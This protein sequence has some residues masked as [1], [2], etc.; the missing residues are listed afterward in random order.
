MDLKNKL[1]KPVI[2]F[3]LILIAVEI[4][5]FIANYKP[6]TYLIG[7]DN[8]MPEF[9]LPLNLNRAFFSIWQEYRGLGTLDG[10][11]HAANLMHTIYIA[12]LSILLPDSTLRYVYTHL[13]HI[14]GGISFFFLLRKLTKNDNASFI[15]SLFYMFNLGVI[16]MYFAPLEVFTTHFAALPLLALLITNALEKTN[17][18]SLT[19]LFLGCLFVSPQG[20]VP[21]VF[22][23]FGILAG[24]MLLVDLIKHRDYRKIFLIILVI[25][26]ANAFWFIPYTVSA[27]ETGGDIKNSRINQ[28]SSEEIFF[29]NK[30]FGDIESVASLKGFMIDTIELD[31]ETFSNAYFMGVW[32]PLSESVYYLPLYLIFFI[33][34]GIGI[35]QVIIKGKE[36]FVPYILTII[37]AFIVLANNTPVAAE[38]NNVIRGTFPLINEALR[39]PFTKFITL[40][41]FCF[42]V[43]FTFGFSFIL[44]RF[45]KFRNFILAFTL[46]II[47]T[48][49]LPAFQGYFTSPY[50]KQELPQE[51]LTFFSD[52][53][54][55]DP[56]QR[57]V[58]FPVQT[59]WNWQYRNWGHRGS[60]FS[61]YGLPQP[62]MERA[63]DPWSPYDE[64]FYNEISYA[65][66]T[67]DSELFNNVLKKYD[68][69]YILVDETILNAIS[70]K[71]INYDSLEKFLHTQ[72]NLSREK[73][74]G[75]LKLY[76]V[77]KNTGWVYALDNKTTKEV[78]P[79]YT[80]EKADSI[81]AL[82]DN[83]ITGA[84]NPSVVNLFPA[85]FS[86]KLQENQEFNITNNKN[87]YI[88]TPKNKFPENLSNYI[89]RIPSIFETE[90]LVPV[91]VEYDSAQLILTPKYPDIKINGAQVLINDDPIKISPK[92]ITNPISVEFVDTK[93]KVEL[94]K[95]NSYAY[96]LNPAINSLKLTD[97]SGRSEIVTLDT[98]TLGS[99]ASYARL[100]DEKVN[101]V[102]ISVPKIAS[103]TQSIS[104]VI[105][106]RKYKINEKVSKFF[107]NPYSQTH[108]RE[109]FGYVDLSAVD[110]SSELTFY[111][112][113][114]FHEAS[115]ILFAKT[116]YLS[117]L[118]MRF[119]A[120]ND[121]ERKAEVETVFSKNIEDTTVVIP[122]ASNFF[123]G[124]GFHFIVKSV[125]KELA[126][127]NIRGIEI[128]PLP[129]G[130]IKGIKF[131]DQET[132]LNSGNQNPKIN[133]GSQ[134]INTSLYVATNTKPGGYIV[135]S[136]AFDNG[137][138]AYEVKNTG[139]LN[140]HFPLI[141]GNKLENHIL[142]N[143]W[144]NGWKSKNGGDT[145]LIF[146]PSYFQYLG[147]F[148]T[149]TT[150][151]IFLIVILK[152]HHEKTKHAHHKT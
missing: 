27:V 9:D 151:L 137:W 89:L 110:G 116:K 34:M 11:A 102:S 135:L 55:K 82:S 104:N 53:Q 18:K 16:Q 103:G 144:A 94:G 72:E 30:S 40:F 126:A 81:Y 41:A 66:N 56:T 119:Y 143:N 74:Y 64:Q 70:A 43:L 14:I 59:F 76:K 134:K 13:T 73:N 133:L 67:Q 147:L 57:V 92:F 77:N 39:F 139:F 87:E 47:A 152:K 51:Y 105:E 38:I 75:E 99:E 36:E 141:S 79:N 63:F 129:A 85:L 98:S 44:K 128:Y 138:Q 101:S 65:T 68:I 48:I 93:D 91:K 8:I 35:I 115:Y 130:L 122:K 49:S 112:P 22:L 58:L 150:L 12:I 21:T 28:F 20:F 61:W 45:S 100:P 136:Q 146:I 4:V 15:G 124:Y 78:Y 109:G 84:N 1:R 90:F 29:R 26:C 60:G 50:L 127:S 118:P 62:I 131:V 96:L 108:S 31:P 83:Y 32:K 149:S 107:S 123:R 3:P 120:D 125:G 80:F 24:F 97:A 142:V 25:F 46:I 140:T 111:M 42:A 113:D 37:V 145:I 121:I 2:Y 132:Y 86:E 95:D 106:Q 69:S 10:L 114:L 6:G 7:W 33:V 117:G 52:M 54:K 23:A 5:L 148:V 71:D 19:Y 88:L 17:L